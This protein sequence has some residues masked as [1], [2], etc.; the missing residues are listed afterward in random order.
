[1]KITDHLKK[2]NIFLDAMLDNKP[3]VLKYISDVCAHNGIINDPEILY[4][5]LIQREQTM[6][7][8]V[9]SGIGF[10]HT[11]NSET[12]H[13]NV[14]LI[15][16]AKP[17]DFESLDHQPVD[18]ILGLIFPDS[19]PG[20]HVRMLARVSRLCQNPDFLSAIKQAE[21]ADLLI[22]QIKIIENS[23]IFH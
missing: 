9:G 16:L 22:E 14:I 3:D 10:P 8:G 5:G 20:I 1:M 18:I 7:T 11:T 15:R 23:T 12:R 6:S 19:D 2:E 21:D 13:A 17:I 4:N